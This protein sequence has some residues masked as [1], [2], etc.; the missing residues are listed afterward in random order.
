MTEGSVISIG[1]RWLMAPD[2]S[3]V[4]E[5]KSFSLGSKLCDNHQHYYWHCRSASQG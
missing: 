2:Y 5:K 1:V 4:S 3:Q